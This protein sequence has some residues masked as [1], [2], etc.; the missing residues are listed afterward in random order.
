MELRR[1][2]KLRLH[3]GNYGRTAIYTVTLPKEWVEALGW[4]PGDKLELTLDTERKEIRVK[5]AAAP[6]L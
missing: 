4:R 5:R 1:E 2:V 6:K 3:R